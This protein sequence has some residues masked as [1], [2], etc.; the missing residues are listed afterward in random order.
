VQLAQERR[1]RGW[2][3][4]NTTTKSNRKISRAIVLLLAAAGCFACAGCGGSSSATA[5]SIPTIVSDTIAFVSD[6]DLN[7]SDARNANFTPNIWAMNADGSNT[8]PLTKLTAA[9]VVSANQ[10]WSPDGSKVVFESTRALNGNDAN[11]AHFN[12]NIWVV[13]ADSSDP[14]PLTNLTASGASSTNPAW[15]PDGSKIAFA[16]TAALDGSDA[17]NGTSN[18]WVMNADGSNLRPLTNLTTPNTF[19]F[20]PIWSPDGSRV[21]FR[22]ARALN[23]DDQ[24][25]TNNVFNT[26]VVNADGS[27]PI[28]LTKLTALNADVLG[29]AWSPDGSKI[30]FQSA[31][32]LDG[33]D[34]AIPTVNE[35]IWVMNADGSRQTPLTQLTATNASSTEPV[36]SKDGTKI[37]FISSRMLDGSNAADPNVTRNIWLMNSDGSSPAPLT[38]L[39]GGA[40][41]LDLFWSPGG[42]KILFDSGRPLDGSDG[43]GT[44]VNI[45]V[46]NADG[47]NPLPLTKL[48]NAINEV[49]VQP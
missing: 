37:L 35:N 15:S 23:G 7:G 12:R 20:T 6:R 49:P 31:R 30:A 46:V 40:A 24:I 1:R 19:S 14:T 5:A 27:N 29:Q 9:N 3:E 16:S 42:T 25:N 38:K 39:T 10:A 45:W 28:P 21:A 18:V 22:S 11:N 26:W 34:A 4:R 17:A 8:R 44:E 33:S 32:A 41:M 47:S 36:W 48:N 2:K 13:D 43:L